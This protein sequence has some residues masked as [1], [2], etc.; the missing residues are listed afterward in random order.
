MKKKDF[1]SYFIPLIVMCPCFFGYLGLNKGQMLYLFIVFSFSIFY[2]L[3]N[4]KTLKTTFS[5]NIVYIILSF[6]LLSLEYF[7][8]TILNFNRNDYS[9]SDFI[10]IL[11]PIVYLFSFLSSLIIIKPLVKRYGNKR[12]F[13]TLERCIFI[14]SV[15][16][17]F[18]FFK[19]FSPFFALYTIFPFGSINYIRMSGTTGFAYSYAWLV[20]IIIFIIISIQ[21]K[22]TLKFIYYA[23]LVLLTGSRSGVFAFGIVLFF[24]F[25]FY[26]KTRLP[27]L[28]SLFIISL[29]ITIL[30]FAEVG[31]VKTS[32][33][34]IIRLILTVLGKSTDGSFSTRRRQNQ[35]AMQ[36]F[37]E[38]M[39]FGI[40]S[41]KKNNITIE[42][43][44]FH[45]LRNWGL[46]GLIGYI[47]ILI[48]F[49]LLVGKTYRKMVFI[50][51]TTSFVISFSSP[52]F[53]Q[54]RNFNILYLIFA[55]MMLGKNGNENE[56][57]E[58]KLQKSRS[59]NHSLRRI[60]CS[61]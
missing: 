16:E 51:L 40:A 20:I 28:I 35:I 43:F 6:L 58:N 7:I 4:N 2:F 53:D 49:F 14:F 8:S 52:I 15:I 54:V 42:N 26:K 36:Y 31:V 3:I 50:I 29:L 19:L 57:M 23:F 30:Y 41:N 47:L 45:H 21:K 33:D 24:I 18:K 55:N 17:I 25:V 61:L 56:S 13:L 59:V 12:I 39:L 60:V 32:I 9:L 34:Y 22:L 5:Y 1:S 46:L 38:H 10:E 48:L 27:L 11:R 44:Y 37:D